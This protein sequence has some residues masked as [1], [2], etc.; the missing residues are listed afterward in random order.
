[1]FHRRT[2]L[3]FC[4]FGLLAAI[5]A[6]CNRGGDGGS[7]ATPENAGQSAGASAPPADAKTPPESPSSDPR[8][9]VVVVET[10]L[11]NI[12]LQLDAVQAPLTVKNFLDYA[13]SGFYDQTIIHQVYKGQGILAGGYD[14]NY[15][16]K[17]ARPPIRNEARNGLKNLRGTVAM[18]RRPDGVDS[19]TS[20]FFINVA[21]NPSLDHKDDSPEGYGYCVFGK[22]TEGMEIVDRINAAPLHDTPEL[23]RTPAQAIVVKTIRRVR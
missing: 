14:V 13:T 9:P 3:R 17:P 16:E 6:G 15:A 10:S 8:H 12:T 23:E 19:A 1:M 2:F 18:N 22:V 21:D 7:S 4:C 5:V 11:G 20:Q